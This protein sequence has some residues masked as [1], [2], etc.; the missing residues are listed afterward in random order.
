[1]VQSW[2]LLA[3]KRVD[4]KS[5]EREKELVWLERGGGGTAGEAA[6]PSGTKAYNAGCILLGVE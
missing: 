3:D 1:M 2:E 5:G 4:G 6:E